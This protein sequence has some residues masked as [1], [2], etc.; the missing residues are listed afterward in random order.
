MDPIVTLHIASEDIAAR[1][2]T[3]ANQECHHQRVERY[4]PGRQRVLKVNEQCQD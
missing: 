3:Q 2:S 4:K 1:H